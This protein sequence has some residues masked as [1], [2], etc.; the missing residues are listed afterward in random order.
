VRTGPLLVTADEEMLWH[1]FSNIVNN[2]VKFAARE[3]GRRLEVSAAREG[4]RALA[5]VVDNGIGMTPEEQARAFDRF[6]Q[7]SA[8]IEGSG[9]GLSICREIME[10]M[11]GTI[12]LV[13]AGRG[14]GAV[15]TVSLPAA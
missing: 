12:E 14:Q 5:R 2:A 9:V 1:V 6:Y 4:E 13:S 11:G 8:T 15:A 10:G 7:A 3:G